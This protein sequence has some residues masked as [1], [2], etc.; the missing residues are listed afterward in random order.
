MTKLTVVFA[1]LRTCL[2]MQQKAWD[3][4]FIKITFISSVLNLHET[5]RFVNIV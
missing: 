3:L 5:S 4:A 1:N 2:T